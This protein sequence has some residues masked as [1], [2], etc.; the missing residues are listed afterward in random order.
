[1]RDL[2][3]WAQWVAWFDAKGISYEDRGPAAT[4]ERSDARLNRFDEFSAACRASR[5]LLA[6]DQR[7]GADALA[8]RA[9]RAWWS[10]G[11]E[12][13]GAELYGAIGRFGEGASGLDSSVLRLRGERLLADAESRY[14]ALAARDG[15]EPPAP[16]P[17]PPDLSALVYRSPDLN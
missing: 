9:L 6:L 2:S 14:N 1:M 11:D 7:G 15:N 12:A 8:A 13:R 10:T 3:A 17:Q 5:R 16:R 4:G